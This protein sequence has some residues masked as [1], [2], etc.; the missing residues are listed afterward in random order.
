MDITNADLSYLGS[1][2]GE[3]Y[4]VA[5]RD[6]N[7]TEQPDALLT[8]VTGNV[9]NSVFSNDY[10][11]IYTFQAQNMVFRGNK[12]HH[13]IGYG[14][15]PH[16]F[17]TGFT[18]EDNESFENGNH[19]FII[20]RGCNNFAF[21]RNISHDNHYTIGTEDRKAHGFI[22]DPGSPNS[23]FPQAPSHDNLLDN[24][25]AYGNDGYG[26]RIVGSINNTVTNNTFTNNLQ[27][28]TLEQASTGNKLDK[29]T[30]TG[31]GL[32]GIYLFGASDQT[33]IT[34]NTI[35][36]SG[37]HGIYIKTGKNTITGNTVTDNGSVV[38]GVGSGSGIATLRE[39]DVAAAAR[40]LTLPGARTSI[41]AEAPELVA[42]TQAVSDVDSNVLTSNTVARNADEGIELKSATNTRVEAKHGQRQRLERRV[43]LGWGWHEH[44]QEER[45]E[46][47][48][49][50]WDSR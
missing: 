8:R 26:L 19:G 7:S 29:N 14:F 25:Q 45:A 49:W 47:Q 35:T 30:I 43:S 6:I 5:W 46:R 2:D 3:S 13:N 23:R 42:T 10:Y 16:D 44:A 22:L 20:S 24:N 32:Y 41:A 50:L 4:G 34:N 17:S 9:L 21:R 15:D 27:G 39:S 18:V 37:K 38:A 12:F 40:D 33:T 36:K 1:A 28:V 48:P 11:G 31:S